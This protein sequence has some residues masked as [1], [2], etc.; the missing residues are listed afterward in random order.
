MTAHMNRCFVAPARSG[1]T[2]ACGQLNAVQGVVALDEPYSRD[3]VQGLDVA[4]FLDLI[5]TTFQNER[6]R[7]IEHGQALST[8]AV[9]KNALGNHYGD[10]DDRT[11]LRTR[12]VE[13]GLIDVEKGLGSDFPLIAKHTIPFTGIIDRLVDLYPT[14]VLVRN[15]LAILVSWNSIEASYRDGRIQ[16][17]AA[18]LTGDLIDRLNMPDRLERQVL[19]LEWHFEKF[20]VVQPERVF[21]Y[22]DIVA[23]GLGPLKAVADPHDQRMPSRQVAK[24]MGELDELHRRLTALPSDSAIF[25]FYDHASIDQLH[26]NLSASALVMA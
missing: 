17:Y 1:S 21:R 22:E 15:P 14:Y 18:A 6:R 12:Q 4:G 2:W 19:L 11:G 3:D 26:D 25:A 5:E 24:A 9:G 8:K 23:S 10:V 7:I 16:P 13:F 20:L